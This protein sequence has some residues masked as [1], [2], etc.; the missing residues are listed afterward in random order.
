MLHGRRGLG[1][2]RIQLRDEIGERTLCCSNRCIISICLFFRIK[3]VYKQEIIYR[4]VESWCVKGCQKA[5][6]VQCCLKKTIYMFKPAGIP[7]QLDANTNQSSVRLPSTHLLVFL[8][9]SAGPMEMFRRMAPE[10]VQESFSGPISMLIVPGCSSFT[11]R[12]PYDFLKPQIPW[13]VFSPENKQ[14]E[15]CKHRF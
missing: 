8:H 1:S 14:Q 9:S 4:F 5:L 15:I 2:V 7:Q 6:Y 11:W 10:L 3:I 12:E 13:E